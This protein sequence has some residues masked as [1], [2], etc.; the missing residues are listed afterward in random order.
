MRLLCLS[1]GSLTDEV[2]RAVPWPK[3]GFHSSRTLLMTVPIP[4]WA[5]TGK[6]CSLSALG[7]IWRHQSFTHAFR[8][9]TTAQGIALQAGPNPMTESVHV[10]EISRGENGYHRERDRL[11]W[12]FAVRHLLSGLGSDLRR[13]YAKITSDAV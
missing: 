6:R 10:R 5:L 13:R 11:F 4:R 2:R 9:R 12:L 7:A 1:F 3:R 8:P